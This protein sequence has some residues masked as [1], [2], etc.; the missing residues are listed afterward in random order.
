MIP[1]LL[2]PLLLSCSCL[3]PLI[4]KHFLSSSLSYPSPL[5]LIGSPHLITPFHSSAPLSSPRPSSYH[6][7]PH[8]LSWSLLSPRVSYL[9]LLSSSWKLLF[10]VS[11][12]AGESEAS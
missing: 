5:Y 2:D 9:L 12:G 6:I 11:L 10:V 4:F 1:S 3:P 8:L 7:T